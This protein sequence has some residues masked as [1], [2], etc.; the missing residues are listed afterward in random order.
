VRQLVIGDI[1][2]CL[3]EL[4]DLLEAAGLAADDQ[5][6]ALGDI[7]DRGPDSPRVLRF[8]HETPHAVSLMGNHERKHVR[9]LRGQVR[10]ALSQ[11]ITRRQI[12]EADYAGA[13]RIMGGF[14][15]HRELP[16]ALLVHGF[17]EPG[18]GLAEQRESVLVGTLSGEYRLRGQYDR[19]WY[20]LYDG[21]KPLIVGHHDY[22][23]NGQP[24]ICNDRVYAIDT[25]CCH[26]GRLTGLLLPEFQL[27]SVASRRDYWSELQNHHTDL[28]HRATP[29]EQLTWLAA[30]RIAARLNREPNPPPERIERAGQVRELLQNGE[31]AISGLYQLISDRHDE[32]LK[33]ISAEVDLNSLTAEQLG[34]RYAAKLGKSP[35]VG[36]LHRMRTGKLRLDTLK[37]SFR[38]PAEAIR[39]VQRM[40]KA[41]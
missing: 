30:E 8:F 13:C 19:P 29:V 20:E 37:Y 7:V 15:R 25:G 4:Q 22:L 38:G 11:L 12:G 18:R 32:L 26:G 39:F 10:P 31:R 33:Q 27:V 28:R 36:Y 40:P 9:S 34:S 1:H 3:D 23:R 6:I 24:L 35:L 41:G 2:G 17:F 14:P 21:D 5:I 16:E